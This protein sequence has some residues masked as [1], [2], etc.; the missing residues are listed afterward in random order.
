M[1]TKGKLGGG[2]VPPQGERFERLLR[3]QNVEIE[4]IIS[5]NSP[6]QDLY[7]QSQ[8]EWVLLLEGEATLEIDGEP[9]KLQAGEWLFLPSQ[10]PHRVLSTSSG[11]RWLA[12]H[13]Y[14]KELKGAQD[15]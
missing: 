8:D 14:P 5:S 4:S 13:I 3:C 11:A 1:I 6:E 9:C 15:V 7:Q 2:G 10:Q 12:I